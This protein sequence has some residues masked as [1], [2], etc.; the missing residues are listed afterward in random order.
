MKFILALIFLVSMLLAFATYIG[1]AVTWNYYPSQGINALFYQYNKSLIALHIIVGFIASFCW[2]HSGNRKLMI[3]IIAVFLCSLIINFG[4]SGIEIEKDTTVK[5]DDKTYKVSSFEMP[6]VNYEPPFGYSPFRM[7]SPLENGK[8]QISS[9][10]FA[11]KQ[12]FDFESIFKNEK[13]EKFFVAIYTSYPEKLDEFVNS[14]DL[15]IIQRQKY[16]FEIY[17]E[18]EFE[19][20]SS[21]QKFQLFIE[22]NLAAIEQDIADRTVTASNIP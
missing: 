2:P 17:P 10:H 18:E 4:V 7:P 8:D 19:A 22:N 20:E 6:V 9:F 5:V 14:D 12:Q 3:S 15:A 16:G 21:L 13:A 11:P 1:A